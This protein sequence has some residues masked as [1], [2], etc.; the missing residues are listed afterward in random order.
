VCESGGRQQP[1]VPF[2]CLLQR[3]LR[4]AR[5]TAWVT[6]VFR[7]P[8]RTAASRRDIE[9][10]VGR[11]EG[12]ETWGE[13]AYRRLDPELR[14]RFMDDVISEFQVD[15]AAA[16][17]RGANVRVSDDLGTIVV[18]G[19][20][21]SLLGLRLV[22]MAIEALGLGEGAI[23]L[24]PKGVVTMIGLLL[25]DDVQALGYGGPTVGRG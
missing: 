25:Y 15:A 2:R 13:A 16:F 18:D 9:Q 5:R 17:P 14:E 20:D 1:S 24:E 4:G 11:V 21:R 10:L 3:V 19:S 7:E 8:P 6:G 22:R 12:E 23:A